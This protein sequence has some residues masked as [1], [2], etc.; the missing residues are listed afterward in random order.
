MCSNNDIVRREIWFQDLNEV[1]RR[2]TFTGPR[3]SLIRLLCGLAKSPAVAR[4]SVEV[5]H[6]TPDK[7]EATSHGAGNPSVAPANTNEGKQAAETAGIRGNGSE[8][9]RA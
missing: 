3:E 6:L 4:N 7:P 2:F 5:I 8:G 1:D 9:N